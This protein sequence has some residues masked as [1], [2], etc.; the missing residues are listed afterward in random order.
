MARIIKKRFY[1]S[2]AATKETKILDLSDQAVKLV[3]KTV[4]EKAT[5]KPC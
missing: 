5:S 1:D 3:K 4:K 2:T